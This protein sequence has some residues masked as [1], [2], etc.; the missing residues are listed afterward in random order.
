MARIWASTRTPIPG[1][2]IGVSTQLRASRTQLYWTKTT[3]IMWT[4]TMLCLFTSVIGGIL[5]PPLVV[6]LVPTLAGVLITGI[7]MGIQEALAKK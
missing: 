3:K 2:R 7:T 4:L 5:F 1:V 6:F